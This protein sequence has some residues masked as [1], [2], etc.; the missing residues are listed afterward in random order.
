MFDQEV[1]NEELQLIRL[2]FLIDPELV[3][4]NVPEVIVLAVICEFFINVRPDIGAVDNPD[5]DAAA[6]ARF[7]KVRRLESLRHCGNSLV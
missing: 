5:C 6:G 4:R 2:S 3:L 7:L 1:I